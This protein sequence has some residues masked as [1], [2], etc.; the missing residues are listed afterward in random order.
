EDVARNV[1]RFLIIGRRPI[2]RTGRDKTSLLLSIKD[3]VGALYRIIEPFAASRLNLSKIES[4]PTRRRPWEYVFFLD[5]EGHQTDPAVQTMLAA[6]RERC[7]FLK[8]LGSYP[9]A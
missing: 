6:L 3:E 2:G 1:T 4:R 8:V 7:L 9:A 5:F